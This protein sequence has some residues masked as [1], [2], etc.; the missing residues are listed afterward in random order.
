MSNGSKAVSAGLQYSLE[1]M[2]ISLGVS[3]TMFNDVTVQPTTPGVPALSYTGNSAT[4][5]G[6]KVAFAF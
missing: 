5:F 6:V 4:T 1:N 3:H 2:N